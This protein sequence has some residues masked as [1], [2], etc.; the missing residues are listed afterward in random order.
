[1]AKELVEVFNPTVGDRRAVAHDE[2]FAEIS[3]RN[4]IISG[5]S[6]AEARFRVPE[7]FFPA[8]RIDRPVQK[9]VEG[10]GD[11][12]LLFDAENVA[13]VEAFGIGDC[14]SEGRPSGERHEMT[15]RFVLFYFEPFGSRTTFD[16]LFDFEKAMK[17]AVGE[18]F[19]AR[20]LING[21]VLPADFSFDIRG[22]RLFSDPRLDGLGFSVPDLRPSVVRR[23]AGRLIR[24]DHRGDSAERGDFA[25]HAISFTRRS[26]NAISSSE[27]PYFA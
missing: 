17:L 5:E 2:N 26:I 8:F 12:R 14:G 24:V 20:I 25:R 7:V 18:G 6:L 27:S 3:A 1:M 4:E 13:F 19:S 15:V 23:V 21:D 16:V 9:I 11:R 22:V 10:V